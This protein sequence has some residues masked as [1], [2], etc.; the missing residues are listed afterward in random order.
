MTVN[1]STPRIAHTHARDR[2][3]WYHDPMVRHIPRT[4]PTSL[5]HTHPKHMSYVPK[6]VCPGCLRSTHK[7]T[8][9]P[10]P[11]HRPE[12]LLHTA[13][14]PR[15]QWIARVLAGTMVVVKPLL[16][17]HPRSEPVTPSNP[18]FV[19]NLTH[20]SFLLS[21]HRLTRSKLF[22]RFRPH[23]LNFLRSEPFTHARTNP[24]IHTQTR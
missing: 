6:P 9:P 4:P 17:C 5:T 14:L 22:L 20:P 3:V 11:Q 23:I 16:G 1:P 12:C 13:P 10:S 2:Y 8:G 21:E 7:H 19:L 15:H 24:T 18:F